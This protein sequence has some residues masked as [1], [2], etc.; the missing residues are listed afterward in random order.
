MSIKLQRRDFI[1]CYPAG[2]VDILSSSGSWHVSCLSS[3]M[4]P[5][6]QRSALSNEAEMS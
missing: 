2:S 5:V 1:S 3:P 4:L 6:T